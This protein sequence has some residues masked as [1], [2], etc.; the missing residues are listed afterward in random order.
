MPFIFHFLIPTG[1]NHRKTAGERLQRLLQRQLAG[2][3][4]KQ[5]NIQPVADFKQSVDVFAGAGD[6]DDFRYVTV[7]QT[8]VFI[9]FPG[10][11]I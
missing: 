8:A 2:L 7:S 3:G 5:R 11:T 6:A 9:I 10:P 1:M 4:K